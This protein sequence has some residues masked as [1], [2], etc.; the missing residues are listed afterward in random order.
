MADEWSDWAKF[1][2]QSIERLEDT[3]KNIYERLNKMSIDIEV[4][5][6][7]ATIAGAIWGSL[8]AFATGSY[9]ISL[10]IFNILAIIT[11]II[12]LFEKD[13]IYLDKINGKDYKDE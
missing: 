10:L 9:T 5:K 11:Y 12:F 3:Q 2:L 8:V 7:K 1:I 6:T 13:I 4:L